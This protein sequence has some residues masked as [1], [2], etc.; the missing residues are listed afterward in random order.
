LKPTNWTNAEVTLPHGAAVQ[1]DVE[2]DGHLR[3]NLEVHRDDVTLVLLEN[4][5][6]AAVVD[7]Q[8]LRAV[9]AAEASVPS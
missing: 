9:L 3:V 5:L 4:A 7:V 8:G 6:R 2:P 1:I